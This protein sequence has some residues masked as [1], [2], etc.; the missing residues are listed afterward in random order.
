MELLDK[1][2]KKGKEFISAP[3]EL[4]HGK[5]TLSEQL[6]EMETGRP[7]KEQTDRQSTDSNN[8]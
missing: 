6:Q 1:Y 3:K 4:K 8:Y 2:I 7:S 5:K